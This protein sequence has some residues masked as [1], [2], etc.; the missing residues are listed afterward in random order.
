MVQ[1]EVLEEVASEELR[2]YAVWV[3]MLRTDDERS[4]RRATTFLPD[5]RVSHYWI[6]SQGLGRAFQEPL[7]L[8]GEPAWD[9]YLLFGPGRSWSDGEVPAPDHFMHQLS[10]RLPED[11]RLDGHVLAEQ[12]G[13]LLGD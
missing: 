3:P 13:T 7:A 8:A 11:K 4:A 12:I 6:P 5:E 2:A 9:V 10:G 1:E